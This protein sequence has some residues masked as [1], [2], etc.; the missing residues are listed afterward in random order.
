MYV[1]CVDAA[2]CYQL[3]SMVCRSVCSSVHQSV[4]LTLVSPAKMAEPIKMPF[5][6]RTQLS[7]GN[8]VLDG[9]PDSLSEGEIF[10][11]ESGVPL[12]NIGTH[13]GHLCKNGWTDQDAVWVEDL[14]GPGNHVLDVVQIPYGKGQFLFGKRASHWT[15]C[16]HLCKNGWSDWCRLGC[17]LGWAQRCVC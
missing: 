4:T 12:Q 2:Y 17:G 11:G 6:L 15:L 7:P 9:G 13:C 8:H 1:V 16:S 3:S 10:S 5:G 14:G